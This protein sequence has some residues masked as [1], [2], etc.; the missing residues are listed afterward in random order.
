LVPA[1]RHIAHLEG[2]WAEGHNLRIE[3]VD[4]EEAFAD[5]QK[6]R[7]RWHNETGEWIGDHI[8][9]IEAG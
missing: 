4:S 5:W 3:K 6:R 1:R 9:V 2:V 8:S 7:E